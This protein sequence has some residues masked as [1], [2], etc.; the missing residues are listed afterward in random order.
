V[1]Y[2][3]PDT[4]AYRKSAFEGFVK[5]PANTG[6]VFYS[7]TSPSY[8]LMKAVTASSSNDDG[9]GSAGIIA[10]IVLAVLALV[11]GLAWA[12]R[13]RTADERE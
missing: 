11:G 4:Q 2:T 1:L 3:Y 9:G 8:S 5:Q 7:N 13:R 6:P 12:R 10:V